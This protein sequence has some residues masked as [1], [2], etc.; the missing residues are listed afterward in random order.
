MTLLMD[1]KTCDQQPENQTI[2]KRKRNSLK[3]GTANKK[4]K[5][6]VKV[7]IIALLEMCSL[8]TSNVSPFACST[9]HP[10]CGSRS[11]DS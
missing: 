7:R 1:N 4:P 5:E 10:S 8:L 2:L 9:S 11:D 3:V 6:D